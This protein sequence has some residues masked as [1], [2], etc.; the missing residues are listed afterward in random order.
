[1]FYPRLV[2]LLLLISLP[3]VLSAAEYVGAKQCK[4]CH[5]QEYTLWQGS[6]HDMAMK[7]ANKD[8]VL[9]NFNNVI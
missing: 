7:H 9:G 2:S 6:H 8:S 4:N 3:T 1:M 5:Q